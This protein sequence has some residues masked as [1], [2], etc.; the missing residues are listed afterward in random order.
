VAAD[1][2]PNTVS[3]TWVDI[4]RWRAVN[5]ALNRFTKLHGFAFC[6]GCKAQTTAVGL[7]SPHNNILTSMKTHPENMPSMRL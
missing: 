7:T 6:C 3:R 4:K 1:K 2:A 5:V